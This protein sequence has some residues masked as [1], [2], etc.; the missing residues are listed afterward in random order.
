MNKKNTRQYATA[1][2]TSPLLNPK[3]TKYIQSVTGS[4]LYYGRALDHS[5]LPALN[6]IASEQSSPTQ[7]TK[8]KAQQLMDYVATYPTPT[9]DI[10]Q[11][12]GS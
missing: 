8:E 5:I 1:P 3:E 4:M 11:V 9:S 2:D 6:E 12:K 7:S 10:M